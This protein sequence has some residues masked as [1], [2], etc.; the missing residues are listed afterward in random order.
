MPSLICFQN[1]VNGVTLSRVFISSMRKVLHI[2][3]FLSLTIGANTGFAQDSKKDLKKQNKDIEDGFMTKEIDENLAKKS[4][5]SD[6][7][8]FVFNN[9]NQ[10]QEYHNQSEIDKIQEY[11]Y[12]GDHKRTIHSLEKYISNFGVFNFAMDLD[13]LWQLAQLYEETLQMDKARSAYTLLLKHHA[14]NDQKEIAQ[15]FKIYEHYDTLTAL[16]KDYYVPLDYYYKLVNFRKNIDTLRPPKSV[17]LNM[18][19]LVNKSKVADY[20]PSISNLDKVMIFTRKELDPYYFGG[21]KKYNEDL[22][23]TINYDGFWDEATKFPYPVNSRCNEG[24]ACLSDDGRTLVFSRCMVEEY[25]L[26]CSDCMGSCDLYISEKIGDSTWSK[27]KNLGPNVNTKNWESHPAFSKYEDTLYFVSDRKGGFGMSDIYYTTKGKHGEWNKALNMGPM[28]NTRGNEY[29]PF[30][31]KTHNVFYFSSTGQ[32]FNFDDLENEKHL[33]TVDIY[34]SWKE[35][36]HWI[37]PKNIGPLV[38]GAGN[39]FYF[40]IDSKAEQLF[41]AKTEENIENSLVTDLFSFPVPME[42]Q[43]LAT[44]TLSGTLR[45][46]ETGSIYEGIISVIDLESGIEVAPKK[47]RPD[48]SF[49]FDLIDHNNYLL[50]VQGDEFFRIEKLFQLDGDMNMDI[51]ARNIRN[52]KLKFSSIEFEN[53]KWDILEA[54]EKDLWDVINFMVD[55]PNFDLVIGGHTDSDGNAKANQVLSQRRAEAIKAF[56]EDKGY[57]ESER[58]AAIGFGDTKPIKTPEITNEDKAIN[59][60]VE[61]EIKNNA[62]RLKNK[63]P[64]SEFENN[65]NNEEESDDDW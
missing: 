16:T 58:V 2:I 52:R 55:N 27:P 36:G 23:Q 39:E 60:R 56:I 14:R 63:I 1:Q 28:I 64:D 44:V 38:N 51:E 53:G 9:I 20:G 47:T 22:Y 48:G 10:I 31:H 6:Q 42:A 30:V 18:G 5:G 45:D 37:E 49:E 54:M 26:D 41:Y 11:A 8:F 7:Y 43:P 50:I 13:L 3:L 4:K 32:L 29:S 61:F 19:N 25:R 59:R 34:R 40:S 57:I 65:F 33:R 12:A 24:S 15:F 17:L 21:K 46:E 62:E 35:N